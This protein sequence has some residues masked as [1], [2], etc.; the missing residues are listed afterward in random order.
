MGHMK[1]KETSPWNLVGGT[2]HTY[3]DE[4]VSTNRNK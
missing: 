2:E 4:A 3:D 1:M